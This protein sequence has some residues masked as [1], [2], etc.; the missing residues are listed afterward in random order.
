MSRASARVRVWYIATVKLRQW[1]TLRLCANVCRCELCAC[2]I[3]REAR[4]GAKTYWFQWMKKKTPYQRNGH[5]SLSREESTFKLIIKRRCTSFLISF[6]M[7]FCITNCIINMLHGAMLSPFSPF[8]SPSLYIPFVNCYS[9]STI[10]RRHRRHRFDCFF[11]VLRPQRVSQERHM[12]Q[13]GLRAAART[14]AHCI[15]PM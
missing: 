5:V 3:E 2:A 1:L 9:M 15:R 14:R 8:L 12:G 6:N 13:I 11:L 10:Y 4:N 7:Q